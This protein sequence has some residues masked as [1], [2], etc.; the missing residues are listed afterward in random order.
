MGGILES[1]PFW[2]EIGGAPHHYIA[3][4]LF[5]ATKHLLED[6]GVECKVQSDPKTEIFSDI[7]SVDIL[8]HAVLAGVKVWLELDPTRRLEH[9]YWSA[10]FTA[11]FE[12]VI[13]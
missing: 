2:K 6:I 3:Q 12:L 10:E 5:T 11:L 8:T 1:S 9:Q 4:T 13:L 7:E